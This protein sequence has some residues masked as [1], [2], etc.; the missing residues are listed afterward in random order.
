MLRVRPNGFT[1]LA[2]MSMLVCALPTKANTPA[3][4]DEAGIVTAIW[5]A[6]N[7]NFDYH[8]SSTQYSCVGLSAKIGSILRAVG[9]H[10]SLSVQ[11]QC[12][13][14]MALDARAQIFVMTPIEATEENVRAVTTYDSH[15]QLV[16]R[17]RNVELVTANDLPRFSAT[18]RKIKLSRV[19]AL[20]LEAG[21]CDLIRGMREHVFPRLSI[22]VTRT[23][24]ACSGGT[25]TRTR[26]TLE[27][28]ALVPLEAPAPVAYVER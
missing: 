3:T 1:I 10:E 12:N 21:D 18:W 25:A 24:V 2:A 6:Q 15:D 13:G 5:H 23:S 28:A 9:A 7:F 11:V 14:S 8:S 26:P 22:E 27:V 19:R 16:A 4:D 20:R 17:V